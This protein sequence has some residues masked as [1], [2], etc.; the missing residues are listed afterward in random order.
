MRNI[1][2]IPD[3]DQFGS[4]FDSAAEDLL[5]GEDNDNLPGPVLS[6]TQYT[7]MPN[8]TASN[9]PSSSMPE[10]CVVSS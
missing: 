9:L 7:H 8:T 2:E 3:D 5:I 6:P 1:V 4:D 10:M